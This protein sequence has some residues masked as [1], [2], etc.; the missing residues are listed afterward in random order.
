MSEDFQR[1]VTKLWASLGLPAP[2]FRAKNRIVL[3]IDRID[4]E[5]A[6]SPD[7]GHIILTARAGRLS[8]GDP[9]RRAEQVQNILYSNLGSLTSHRVCVSV[10]PKG[11]DDPTVLVQGISAYET[12]GAAELTGVVQD[13][14]AVAEVHAAELTG[15]RARA[16]GRT[17]ASNQQA[18]GDTVIFRP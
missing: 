3:S 4:V 16:A 2:V 10:D 15:E 14:V 12:A 13:V 11:A 17:P 1:L 8:A 5:L 18:V 9:M 7:G 6:E